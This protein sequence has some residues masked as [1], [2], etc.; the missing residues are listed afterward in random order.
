MPFGGVRILVQG[1]IHAEMFTRAHHSPH[2][3]GRDLEYMIVYSIWR[4][5][6][7][8]YV[9]SFAQRDAE[10]SASRPSN[11]SG[12]ERTAMGSMSL[13]GDF[14]LRLCR[15]YPQHGSIHPH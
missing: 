10:R 9:E 12:R 1:V 14:L 2:L 7:D 6:S 8:N 4:D 3:A 11:A 5:Y 13:N 15:A